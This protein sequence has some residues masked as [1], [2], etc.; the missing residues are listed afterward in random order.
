MRNIVYR[1]V[2]SGQHEVIWQSLQHLGFPVDIPDEVF[3]DIPHKGTTVKVVGTSGLPNEFGSY[4]F[5]RHY[6]TYVP[7][8]VLFMGDP[9]NIKTWIPLKKQYSFPLIMYVT[10]D[11]LPIHP[12]WL[13][14]LPY[15]NL[16][17][18]MTEWAQIEFMKAGL[19]VA[20]IHHGVN[21]NWWVNDEDNKAKLRANYGLDKDTTIFINRE[22]NQHR[23]RLDIL[24]RCWKAFRPESKDAKLLLW[25]PWQS[26]QGWDIDYKIKQYEVPRETILSPEDILGAG[27]HKILECANRPEVE[28]AIAQMGDIY[29]TSSSGE[30]FGKNNLEAM[31]LGQP[32]IATKCSAIPEV[33]GKGG[34]LVPTYEG[35]AG[36]YSVYDS[37]RSVD[38]AVVN[39]EKFVDAMLELYQ[40]PVE[41]KNLGYVA[42]EQARK[43]DYDAEIIPAWLKILSQINPDEIL[44]KEVLNK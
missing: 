16:L 22:S 33:I 35:E 1:L 23:K 24:L 28:R 5:P 29:L 20:Y 13:E 44:V 3:P 11:G 39:M 42:R 40:N 2:Q 34:I 32:V 10:L 30:G 6:E 41:R 15:C 18:A 37:A 26:W 17:I 19:S 8:L 38:G 27:Q 7:D 36:R 9:R 31:S 25:T 21:W 4:I 43:F 14:Y 12:Q